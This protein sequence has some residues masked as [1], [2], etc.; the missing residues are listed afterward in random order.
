M[1]SSFKRNLLV[2]SGLSFL[3][4]IVSAIASYTSI[5]NLLNSQQQVAH[6]NLVINKL[7]N[8]IS[9]LKDAE[10]GQRGFLLTGEEKFLEP[11]NGSLPKAYELISDIKNLTADNPRQLQSAEQLRQ[12]I[13]K[14]IGRLQSLIDNKR[15]GISPTAAELEV[16]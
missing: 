6:T 12:L 10:T 13:T 15:K 2:L 3:L 11:Y 4:L 9:V 14:R 16:G 5:T 1:K 8:V 7:D